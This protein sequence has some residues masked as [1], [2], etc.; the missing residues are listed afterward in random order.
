MSNKIQARIMTVKEEAL[1]K[2]AGMGYRSLLMLNC[3]YRV[4][5]F[6]FDEKSKQFEGLLL[7]L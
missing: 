6:F 5:N 1:K 7:E 2:S 4:N 3:L